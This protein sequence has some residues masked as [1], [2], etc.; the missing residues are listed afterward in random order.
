VTRYDSAFDVTT[1]Q[2]DE[3]WRGP[4]LVDSFSGLEVVTRGCL[5]TAP[6]AEIAEGWGASEEA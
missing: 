2:N 3:A 6:S 5:G 1:T 4:V